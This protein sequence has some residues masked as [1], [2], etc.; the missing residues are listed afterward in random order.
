MDHI[1]ANT[2]KK[3]EHSQDVPREKRDR[4]TQVE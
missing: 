4:K 1:K 3:T 2:M